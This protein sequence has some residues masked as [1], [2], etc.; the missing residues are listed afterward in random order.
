MKPKNIVA[1]GEN[2]AIK[3]D[4]DSESFISNKKLRDA[5]PCAHCSGETDV[6]GNVY[7]GKSSPD[8]GDVEKYNIKGYM[9]IGHYAI[10][11]V[12]GD[13]HNAGIYSFDLLK[14]LDDTK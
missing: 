3:W 4:D 14:T 7:K 12:W 9:N 13:N 11:I 8:S 5:C 6:F 2:L 10:R 1:M